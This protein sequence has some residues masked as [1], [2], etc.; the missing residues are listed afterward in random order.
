MNTHRNNPT[1][2]RHLPDALGRLGGN[3]FWINPTISLLVWGKVK[4]KGVKVNSNHF[5][6]HRKVLG[7]EG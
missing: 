7:W 4:G 1:S 2:L 5:P 6:P 3:I